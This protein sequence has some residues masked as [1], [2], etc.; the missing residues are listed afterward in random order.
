MSQKLDRAEKER[1]AAEAK[2]TNAQWLRMRASLH[3]RMYRG[4]PPDPVG[5]AFIDRLRNI[6]E[7]LDAREMAA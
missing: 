1:L 5:Q 4:E 2:L 3:E 7:I 6:A